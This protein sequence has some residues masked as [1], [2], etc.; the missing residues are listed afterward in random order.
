V[1]DEYLYEAIVN[2]NSQIVLGFPANVMAQNYGD[3]FT[4]EEIKNMIA[5]IKSLD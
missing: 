1:D 4:D 3:L 2:P 5:F